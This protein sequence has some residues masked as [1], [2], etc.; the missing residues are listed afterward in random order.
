MSPDEQIR[1]RGARAVHGALGGDLY[2]DDDRE[3]EDR[4]SD[5]ISH[6]DYDQRQALAAGLL[7]VLGT[8]DGM[9]EA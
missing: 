6:L 2:P 4:V 9:G 1:Y 3:P 8:I 5:E 7:T